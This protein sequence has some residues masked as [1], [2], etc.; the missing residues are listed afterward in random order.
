MKRAAWFSALLLIALACGTYRLP[1]P[2]PSGTWGGTQGNLTIFPD[3]ATL[4]LP[5]A[6][7]LLYGPVIAGDGGSFTNAGRYAGQA[8]PVSQDGPN[9][10]SAS[11]RG[12]RTG[13][14]LTLLIVLSQ[15]STAGPLH[16]HY[17]TVGQFPRCV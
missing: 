11:F 5:C 8:G 10:E 14:D 9:W 15:G 13:D 17:G 12:V 6:I 7:G 3:S 16:L 2:L 1:G 4:D